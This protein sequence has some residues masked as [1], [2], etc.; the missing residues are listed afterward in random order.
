MERWVSGPERCRA[1]INRQEFEASELRA[2]CRLILK[3][4]K[5][6]LSVPEACVFWTR[7]D[8]RVLTTSRSRYTHLLL[9]LIIPSL[10]LSVPSSHVP[11]LDSTP[12]SCRM[13]CA[14]PLPTLNPQ[15]RPSREKTLEL[16]K[17]VCSFLQNS[18]YVTFYSTAN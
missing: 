7:V 15:A 13:R 16:E 11:A 2:G 18:P 10:A 12:Q 3:A 8:R 5:Q 9:L 17:I 14:I 4:P 6:P 1:I